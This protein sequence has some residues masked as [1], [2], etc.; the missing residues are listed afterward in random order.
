MQMQVDLDGRVRNLSLPRTQGLRPVFEAI[1][2]SIDAIEERGAEGRVVVHIRRDESQM[3]LVAGEIGVQ[4][5][6]VFEITDTGAGFTE[7][8]WR[9]FQ[10]SDTT[11]KVARGGTSGDT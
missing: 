1:V 4:P 6:S 9:A 8:N 11:V 7:R 5:I 10:R 3:A 2:N